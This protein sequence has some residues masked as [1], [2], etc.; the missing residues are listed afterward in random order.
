VSD[1]AD[2]YYSYAPTSYITR[3]N[4]HRS[5]VV[6]AALKENQNISK[7]Q[8]KYLNVID[9]F[10]K[11]LPSNID[12]Q[13]HFDQADN[14]NQRLSGLGKDFIIAICL[15]LLTLLPLGNRLFSRNDIHTSFDGHRYHTAQRIGL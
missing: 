12:L 15:V 2:V 14:V 8:E 13:P 5:I 3:F 4:Y 1:I 11:K 9:Q 6:V 10:K 7:A